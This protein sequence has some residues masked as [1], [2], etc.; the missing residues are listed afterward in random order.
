MYP[1]KKSAAILLSLLVISC[2]DK[3]TAKNTLADTLANKADLAG[4]TTPTSTK[5]IL[6]FGDSLTAG[7]GLDDPSD[8]FP[9]VIKAKIDSLKLPYAVINS[10]VSGETSAGGLSRIDWV[11]KQKP[12]IFLL[13]LG[14]NDGLRGNSVAQTITNLQAIIDKVK[15]KYPDAKIIL[16]GMQVPPS[17]GQQYVNDFK[18][19]YPDLAAKNHIGLVP[20][21]LENVGGITKLNQADGIHPNPTGAKIVA[22]NVWKV[23]QPELH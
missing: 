7:Y 13:E 15:A 6:V 9:G 12:D 21:L 5:T 23:L 2:G 4:Q 1:F 18:K 16:L 22:E 8:A 20:F 10:G 14:A 19:M 17:M 11:L 3:K